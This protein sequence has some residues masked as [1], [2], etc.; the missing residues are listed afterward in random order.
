MRINNAVEHTI[1]FRCTLP[2][3]YVHFATL[4]SQVTTAM[5]PHRSAVRVQLTGVKAL[6]AILRARATTAVDADDPSLSSS[7]SDPLETGNVT[8]PNDIDSQV[9]VSP[10]CVRRCATAAVRALVDHC[11]SEENNAP[12][13]DP[14]ATTGGTWL[15]P[16]VDS[17]EL[18]R[19]GAQLLGDLAQVQSTPKATPVTTPHRD[20]LPGVPPQQQQQDVQQLVAKARSVLTP[21][22]KSSGLG[23]ETAN[24]AG[25]AAPEAAMVPAGASYAAVAASGGLSALADA[26]LVADSAVA[27]LLFP[28]PAAAASSVN[29]S[30]LSTKELENAL[31]DFFEVRRAGLSVFAK[32]DVLDAKA[33]PRYGGKSALKACFAALQWTNRERT[34]LQRAKFGLPFHSPV[35]APLSRQQH[36]Q[37]Q[38]D[39]DEG[40][41]DEVAELKFE[42]AAPVGRPPG[43]MGQSKLVHVTPK[44]SGNSS[45]D[46]AKLGEGLS[47]P[48]EA[49][50]LAGLAVMATVQLLLRVAASDMLPLHVAAAERDIG[51]IQAEVGLHNDDSN[52][53]E[54]QVLLQGA[55]LPGTTGVSGPA[56]QYVDTARWWFEQAHG[57]EHLETCLGSFGPG[58]TS[59]ALDHAGQWARRTLHNHWPE[60]VPAVNGH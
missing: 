12:N 11:L 24:T 14:S 32:H 57:L 53:N 29:S 38:G 33:L 28:S 8:D 3:C 1:F 17:R 59:A 52:S 27:A 36:G 55:G 7:S 50:S 19:A 2:R 16:G 48:S 9:A 54:A 46:V 40:E 15:R 45:L 44:G 39:D 37:G 10:G 30:G 60:Y 43:V 56:V 25:S 20:Q 26:M 35:G 51:R 5:A 58:S 49:T 47:A 34:R 31:E 21:G 22:R 41:D 42:W 13:F 6:R 23:K 18:L 4:I